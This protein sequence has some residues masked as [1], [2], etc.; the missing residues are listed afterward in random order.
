M[1]KYSDHDTA[2][3]CIEGRS[4]SQSCTTLIYWQEPQQ[5]PKVLAVSF[6][7]VSYPCCLTMYSHITLIA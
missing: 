7:S 3:L 5:D 1:G 6:V 4:E 2:V